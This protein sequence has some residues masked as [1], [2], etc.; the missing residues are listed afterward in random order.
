MKRRDF[1]KGLGIIVPATIV[2][3]K[4]IFDYGKNSITAR[5][6]DEAVLRMDDDK[7]IYLIDEDKIRFADEETFARM[8]KEAFAD[9]SVETFNSK[10]PLIAAGR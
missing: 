8:F 3:P 7:Y 1:L 10:F 4:L 6:L 2:A 9:M 5:D